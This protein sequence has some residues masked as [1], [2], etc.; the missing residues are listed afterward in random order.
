M[1]KICDNN[2]KSGTSVV[3]KKNENHKIYFNIVP[4]IK[5]DVTYGYGSLAPL[6]N[7][8]CGDNYLIKQLDNSRII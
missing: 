5:Y 8:I 2:I 1:L 3:Y 7:S 6:G 4:K